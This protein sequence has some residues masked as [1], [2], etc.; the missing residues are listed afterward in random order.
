M[1]GRTL[2]VVL[3]GAFLL[4]Q[5][6]V[7]GQEAYPVQD[8]EVAPEP[9]AGAVAVASAEAETVVHSMRSMG[10]AGPILLGIHFLTF[11]LGL[12]SVLHAVLARSTRVPLT[13]VLLG[14][15]GIGGLIIGFLATVLGIRTVFHSLAI[16]GSA[17]N[18]AVIAEGVSMAVHT[19]LFGLTCA[20]HALFWFTVSMVIF[21]IVPRKAQ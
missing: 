17:A 13:I 12:G 19:S 3:V 11:V 9:A 15:C 16:A 18:S 1:M 21:R 4:G 5:S 14:C 6:V 7:S 10:L 8:E 2:L 20:L